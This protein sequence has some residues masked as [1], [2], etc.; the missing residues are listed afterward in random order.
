MNQLRCVRQRHAK[1]VGGNEGKR[2]RDRFKC[3]VQ[4]FVCKKLETLR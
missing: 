3:I 1:M 2:G 4:T